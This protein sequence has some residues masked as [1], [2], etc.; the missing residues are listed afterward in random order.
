MTTD[1]RPLALG[2]RTLGLATKP[3]ATPSPASAVLLMPI[4]TLTP[5]LAR[6]PAAGPA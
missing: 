5:V 3:A 1:D 2:R 4:Q 6:V